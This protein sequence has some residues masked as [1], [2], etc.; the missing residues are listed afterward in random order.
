M[1]NPRVVC[2]FSC[3][4]TSA[5]AAKM[6]I[7]KY[8]GDHEVVIAYCDTGSEHHDNMRFL[9]DCEHWLGNNY[10]ITILK[11]PDYAN[12]W[13]VFEKRRYLV[14][15]NGAP[16]TN[17]LKKEVRKAFQRPDD[18]QIFGYT[19][20]EQ[21]RITRFRQ[22]NPSVDLECP[23]LEGKLTSENCKAILLDARI[24]LP[25]MYQKQKSGVPY[26]HN[27]CIGCV[28][29]GMGYW[30]KIRIDFP[31]QFNRMAALERKIGRAICKK[32]TRGRQAIPVYLDEL[33]P[34]DGRFEKEKTIQ[35]DMLCG[36]AYEQYG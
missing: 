3:G 8:A 4:A 9:K 14:G 23:L 10:Q 33:K 24:E 27:N 31:E 18:I 19:Y 13:E 5:V 12:I 21:H 25:F 28:K 15:K 29:G 17:I 35:C 11:H 30:N 6:A 32:E 7:K 22:E 26:N 2:W 16:C 34:G 36:L 20:D 1:S